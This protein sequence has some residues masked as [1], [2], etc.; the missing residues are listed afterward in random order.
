MHA[1]VVEATEPMGAVISSKRPLANPEWVF[2]GFR[3]VGNILSIIL[4]SFSHSVGLTPGL[5]DVGIHD[6]VVHVV[7]SEHIVPVI[8]KPSVMENELGVWSILLLE[9]S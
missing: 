3:G 2:G 8:I 1:T 5:I 4:A 7:I 9:L 6:D